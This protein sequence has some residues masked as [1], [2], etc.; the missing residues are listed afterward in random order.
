M[1]PLFLDQRP[2]RGQTIIEKLEEYRHQA[3][4]AIVLATPDDEGHRAGHA[5]ENAYRVRQNVVLELGMMLALLG[6]SRVAILLKDRENMERPSDIEG[7]IYIAFRD[8]VEE[9]GLSLAREMNAQG[10]DVNPA[11]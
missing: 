3:D 5:S 1:E 4:Y 11:R 9:T 7:L 6:R 10:F 2:S 8:H